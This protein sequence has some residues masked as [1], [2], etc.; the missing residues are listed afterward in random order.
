MVV[1]LLVAVGWVMLS[2]EG[3]RALLGIGEAERWAVVPWCEPAVVGM[4]AAWVVLVGVSVWTRS[5][6]AR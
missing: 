6:G 2:A 1:G 4:G 3:M 5:E